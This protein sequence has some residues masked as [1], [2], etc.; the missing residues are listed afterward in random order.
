MKITKRQLKKIIR[1][2][3]F[4]LLRE[5][6]PS[7]MSMHDAADYYNQQKASSG[8]AAFGDGMRML[9]TVI[10]N[11]EEAGDVENAELAKIAMKD[12]EKALRTMKEV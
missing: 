5:E 3:K 11:L 12:L 10:S 4:R 2:E 9:M 6:K 1:E 8:V 7:E